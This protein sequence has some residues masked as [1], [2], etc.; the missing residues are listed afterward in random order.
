MKMCI[1]TLNNSKRGIFFELK[2]ALDYAILNLD[3]TIES[4]LYTQKKR[5]KLIDFCKKNN[6]QYP[7]L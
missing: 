3:G 4:G 2:F 7:L 5:E 1:N 6:V